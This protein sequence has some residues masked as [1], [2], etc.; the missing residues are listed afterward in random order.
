MTALGQ[1]VTAV[2]AP[3]IHLTGAS[4][5]EHA[6]TADG[7]CRAVTIL[8]CGLVTVL[9]RGH[10]RAS[11]VRGQA[12]ELSRTQVREIMSLCV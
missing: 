6:A 11:V 5:G 10:T 12:A 1:L 3:H 7:H 4:L 2:A 8:L 9:I